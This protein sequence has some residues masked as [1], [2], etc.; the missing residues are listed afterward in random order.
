MLG[1]FLGSGKTTTL[2][3]LAQQLQRAGKRVGIIT[4]DQ[5]AGLV[6]TAL[7]EELNLPVSEIAGGCFCCRSGSLVEALGKLTAASQPEVFLAEP[8]GSCTDLVATVSLPLERIYNAG[9]TM[10]PYAVLVDPYRAM[11]TLGV[12]ELSWSAAK[13]GAGRV[14][15]ESAPER[16]AGRVP[17]GGGVRVRETAGGNGIQTREGVFSPD[18]NYIYRKQLEEAEIIVINKTDVIAPERLVRLREALGREY[19]DAEILCVAS[20]EGTGLDALFEAL[21]TREGDTRRV[22]EVD[23][24]RYGK[25]EAML[26]WYNGQHEVRVTGSAVRVPK[27]SRKTGRPGDCGGPGIDGNAWLLDLALRVRTVLR[28][29]GTEIAHFKMSLVEEAAT[30]DDKRADGPG[31]ARASMAAVSLV[32]SDR[33]PELR[34]VLDAPLERGLLTVNLRAEGM[35]ELL[36]IAVQEALK[37]NPPGLKT[38]RLAEE[39]FR[40]GQ[41]IPTHRVAAV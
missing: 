23:Y 34:R 32:S 6:D 35:P 41:P 20:R 36:A 22:M 7:M 37:S 14:A 4:N 9:F 5:A 39:A 8:V 33:E 19:P 25:G 28:A 24:A 1:G 15:G 2:L 3:R 17:R 16:S 29:T 31:A 26:G 10:A 21:T 40:P 38:K 18:V 11:Q 12:E 27:G 30:E 13:A